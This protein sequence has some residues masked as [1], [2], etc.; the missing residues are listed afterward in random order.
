[1]KNIAL[2]ID[3]ES[4]FW[5]LY[6]N[7][8]ERP[9]IHEIMS[10]IRAKGN[11]VKSFAYG[12]FSREKI[13]DERDRLRSESIIIVDCTSSRS[14]KNITDFILLD[15]L[16][17]AVLE[18]ILG[19]NMKIDLFIIVAGDGHYSSIAARLKNI[20]NKEVGIFAVRNTLNPILKESANWY[21]IIEPKDEGIQELTTKLIETMRNL[22]T[23]GYHLYFND[24]IVR[25]ES[26]NKLEFAKTEK[27]RH[28]LSNLIERELIIRSEKEIEPGKVKSVIIPDWNALK[29]QGIIS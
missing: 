25:C 15:N 6:N 29:E 14:D 16:Y 7:F 24:V 2:F 17:G 23:K 3:Y 4:L 1:M 12:D 13:S 10:L 22:E 8:G 20:L 5:G 11:I 21:E 9:Q 19:L 28:I 27:V 18:E 26:Y